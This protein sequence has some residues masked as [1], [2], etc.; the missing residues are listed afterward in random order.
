MQAVCR[1]AAPL[2]GRTAGATGHHGDTSRKGW[3][4]DDALG[5]VREPRRQD[6]LP[7]ELKPLEWTPG[8]GP[9]S[10]AEALGVLRRRRRVELAGAPKTPGPRAGVPEELPPPDAPKKSSIFRLPARTVA[11]AHARAEMEGVPLTAVVEEL[12]AAYADGVPEAPAAVR[13]RRGPRGRA[14]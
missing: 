14:R 2:E 7:G 4:V 5:E 12:L 3:Q 10:D 1:D 13:A 6:A 8:R 9:I 11:R